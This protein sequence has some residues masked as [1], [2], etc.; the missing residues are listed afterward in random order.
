MRNRQMT[1]DCKM[2]ITGVEMNEIK[3]AGM[4]DYVIYQDD[5]AGDGIFAPLVFTKRPA[6]GRNEPGACD[7]I[8]TAKQSHVVS[9]ANQFFSEIR[10]DSLRP[11]IMFW[12]HAFMKR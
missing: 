4:L 3:F 12:R 10:N 6:A 1:R 2:K 5:F 9:C 8:A 11:S 7:R